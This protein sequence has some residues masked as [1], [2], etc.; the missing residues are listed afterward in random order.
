[1]HDEIDDLFEKFAPDILQDQF[2]RLC[3]ELFI[4]ND[5]GRTL[6]G[7]LFK[8]YVYRPF[9]DIQDPDPTYDEKKMLVRIA[10]RDFVQRLLIQA[11]AFEN[12]LK[13]S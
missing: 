11:Q 2:S 5:K 13:K 4:T 8:Q 9:L 10:W 1:M 3:Y 7:L 12:Q 6:M